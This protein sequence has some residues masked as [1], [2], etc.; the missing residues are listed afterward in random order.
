MLSPFCMSL[1]VRLKWSKLNE[2]SCCS[3]M[4]WPK[5]KPKII[6][7]WIVPSF[8]F[9]PT[10]KWRK[11]L[12]PDN[13]ENDGFVSFK[14]SI[15]TKRKKRKRRFSEKV[16]YANDPLIRF[17]GA[18]WVDSGD[19]GNKWKHLNESVLII[20]RDNHWLTS[21]HLLNHNEQKKLRLLL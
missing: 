17:C 2:F 12:K 19:F 7:H 1:C 14:H 8:Y 15:K 4:L 20:M 3:R 13:M 21:F 5:P 16:V 18:Q 6:W 10:T 9:F 11:S